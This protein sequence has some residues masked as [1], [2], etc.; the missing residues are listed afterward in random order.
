MRLTGTAR[1]FSAGSREVIV[2]ENTNTG[3]AP[4][5]RRKVL[6]DAWKVLVQVQR[7]KATSFLEFELKELENLFVVMLIGSLIGLPAPPAALSIEL[8]PLLTDE[9]RLMVSRADMTKD[10]LGTLVGMLNLD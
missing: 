5:V 7:D 3:D 6:R 1:A 9:L 8:L 2:T 10:P 4:G